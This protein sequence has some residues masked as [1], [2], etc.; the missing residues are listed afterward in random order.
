M[1]FYVDCVHDQKKLAGIGFNNVT[2]FEK[3]D[4][5]SYNDYPIQKR[6]NLSIRTQFSFFSLGLKDM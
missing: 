3:N 1:I 5:L 4:D 6:R 2:N